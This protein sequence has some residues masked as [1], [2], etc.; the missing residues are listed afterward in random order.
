[1]I[2]K[3]KRRPLGDGADLLGGDRDCPTE[4]TPSPQPSTVTRLRALHL[5]GACHVRPEL[6]MAL[7]GLAFGGE[8]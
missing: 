1:M 4:N 5:I 8:Q 6:A 7:A 3:Q 2:H